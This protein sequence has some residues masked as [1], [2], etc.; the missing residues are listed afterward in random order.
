MIR[1]CFQASE[2]I[3]KQ[4]TQTETHRQSFQPV[5]PRR[6]EGRGSH[7]KP[8]NFASGCSFC[9]QR[10]GTIHSKRVSIACRD[11]YCAAVYCAGDIPSMSNC[12][13]YIYEIYADPPFHRPTCKEYIVVHIPPYMGS[14]RLAFARIGHVSTLTMTWSSHDFF[15]MAS[16]SFR[17]KERNTRP[18][19]P[20]FR[21]LCRMRHPH[22]LQVAGSCYF[23]FAVLDPTLWQRRRFLDVGQR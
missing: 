20:C 23:H 9:Y 12:I 7:L 13:I 6:Q 18:Q 14:A 2:F 10:W 11:T 3:S 16:A 19:G 22:A 8:S 5:L 4:N 15:S 21:C 17:C 1:F